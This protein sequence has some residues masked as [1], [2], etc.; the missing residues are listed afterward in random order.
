MAESPVF[1]ATAVASA[2][3]H[4]YAACTPKLSCNW[5]YLLSGV[6]IKGNFRK[7]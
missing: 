7:I 1:E 5:N 6:F 2:W 3:N 4:V